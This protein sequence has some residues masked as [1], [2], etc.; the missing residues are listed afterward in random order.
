MTYLIA[1]IFI[2]LLAAAVLGLALGWYLTRIAAAGARNTLEGRLKTTREELRG[3]QAAR[4]AAVTARDGVERERR[5]LSDEIIDLRAELAAAQ[6]ASDGKNTDQ[7]AVAGLE[8][9]LEDCRASLAALTAPASG[10]DQV[11]DTT[12]IASA[13]QAAAAGAQRLMG[14]SGVVSAAS[15]GAA[16]D[17]QRIKGIGPKIAGILSDLGIQQYAQI[18]AWTPENVAWINDYLKFKGRVERERWIEQART[19]MQTGDSD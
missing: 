5:L 17:L 8:A 4:D 13:A 3:M 19:L 18:A 1:Q 7:E 14:S 10:N 9:E 2:L 6:A 12:A 11:A 15:E 16:D